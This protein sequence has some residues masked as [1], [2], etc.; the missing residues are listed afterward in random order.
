MKAKL[1]G[2]PNGCLHRLKDHIGNEL[3]FATDEQDC[4]GNM[5]DES[6]DANDNKRIHESM[7][8]IRDIGIA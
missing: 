8:M 1:D 3:E 5:Q 2:G 6:N 7:C 4:L